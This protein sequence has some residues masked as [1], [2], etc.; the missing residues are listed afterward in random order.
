MPGVEPTLYVTSKCEFPTTGYEVTLTRE[1]PQG[2]NPRDLLLRLEI[3]EPTGPVSEVITEV[4]ARYE[5]SVGG[6]D[7]DTVSILPDGP[8]G[9]EVQIT[10]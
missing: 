7:F 4:E 9:I 3:K 8:T 6:E 2:A 10:K 5:E 1:E